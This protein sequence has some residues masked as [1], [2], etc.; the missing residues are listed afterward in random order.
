MVIQG[1]L[2]K[3]RKLNPLRCTSGTS[4]LGLCY[5]IVFQVL[6][7]LLDTNFSSSRGEYLLF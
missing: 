4:V 7:F 2:T 5:E 3:D 6:Q 1:N